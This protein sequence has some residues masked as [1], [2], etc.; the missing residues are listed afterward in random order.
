[1]R[2]MLRVAVPSLVIL[3]A[4][5]SD[6]HEQSATRLDVQK[7]PA[8]DL[9][10]APK[11][12]TRMRFVSPIEQSGTNEHARSARSDRATTVHAVA[13]VK[14]IDAVRDPIASLA[15]RQLL[16]VSTTGATSSPDVSM[17]LA[18][19]LTAEPPR[20]AMASGE[21]AMVDHAGEASHPVAIGTSVIRGGLMGG[22]KKC[23]PRTDTHTT[24]QELGRPDFAMPA[25]TGRSV[26]G[27]QR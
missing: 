9:A 25:A 5:C 17:T 22:E 19:H 3:L 23:D 18:T 27:R 8:V 14:T 10:S 26:F 20:M 21:A 15:S 12:Y 4:A 11:T 7:K 1:M 16:P 24:P 6:R 13:A 2:T